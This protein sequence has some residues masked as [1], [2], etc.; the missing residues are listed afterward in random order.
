MTFLFLVFVYLSK[1]RNTVDKMTQH[2]Y[3]VLHTYTQTYIEYNSIANS[4]QQEHFTTFIFPLVL[5][6]QYVA[7]SFP[8]A[9]HEST[10]S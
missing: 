5:L 6:Q 2:S 10:L 8:K 4:F 1:D 9:L 3:I 7:F